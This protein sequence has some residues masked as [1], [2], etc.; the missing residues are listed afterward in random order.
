MRIVSMCQP[1]EAQW[2]IC[3]LVLPI[4]IF[5]LI[6]LAL[7]RHARSSVSPYLNYHCHA[8]FM[9]LGAVRLLR[10]LRN[11]SWAPIDHCQT[12]AVSVLVSLY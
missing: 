3:K 1:C 8:V 5:I 12:V 2:S 10:L 11:W 4:E 6:I 7:R 9:R